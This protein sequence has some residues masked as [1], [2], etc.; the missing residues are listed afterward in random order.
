MKV[1]KLRG[2]ILAQANGRDPGFL[3]LATS[4]LALKEQDPEEFKQ[5]IEEAGLGRRRAYYLVQVAQQLR[6]FM[7]DRA[8][9]E[10]IGWTKLRDHRQEAH[11]E[12]GTIAS[13]AGRGEPSPSG[14]RSDAQGDPSCGGLD[15][16]RRTAQQASDA[17][18]LHLDASTCRAGDQGSGSTHPGGPKT[19]CIAV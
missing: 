1:E 6:P 15:P 19:R 8:R 18:V 12:E 5:T 2:A 3:D 16:E 14:C 13:Q 10:R 11:E 7:E 17:T 9:L 4:L